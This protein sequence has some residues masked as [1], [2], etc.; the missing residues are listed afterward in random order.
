CVCMEACAWRRVHGGVCMEAQKR[1]TTSFGHVTPLTGAGG[2]S[3][4]IHSRAS[5]CSNLSTCGT[6]SA[7]AGS[8]L[9]HAH[10]HAK[11]AGA[12][13]RREQVHVGH[14]V[15]GRVDAFV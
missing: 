3:T 6:T 10:V 12:S 15:R 1:H 8:R 9:D 11:A 4:L 14:C 5:C 13:L 2:F 7:Y